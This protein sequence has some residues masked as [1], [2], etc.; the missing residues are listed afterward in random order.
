[1]KVFASSRAMKDN[2]VA[3]AARIRVFLLVCPNGALVAKNAV[4]AD[5]RCK[6]IIEPSHGGRAK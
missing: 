4:N 3:V 2:L 1:M 5:A 6:V